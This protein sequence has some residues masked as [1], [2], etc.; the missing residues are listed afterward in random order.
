MISLWT[1]KENVLTSLT[2]VLIEADVPL[3]DIVDLGRPVT[4]PPIAQ[5][6]RVYIGDVTNDEPQPIWEPGSQL[7]TETYT[8]PLLVD[9][10][11]FTGNQPGGYATAFGLVAAIVAAIEGQIGDDPS[12]GAVVHSSGLA[13]VAEATTAFGDSPGGS[14]W[15][16][17]AILALHVTRKGK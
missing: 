17:G 4:V 10:L 2:T 12:W 5:P 6:R 1:L 16:S 14:G 13:V 15:R 3:A 9:C 7:R 8:V 11:S